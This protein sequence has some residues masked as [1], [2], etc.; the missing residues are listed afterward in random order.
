MN[1]RQ[2]QSIIDRIV[3]LTYRTSLSLERERE[4]EKWRDG[5][6]KKCLHKT[7]PHPNK[8]YYQCPFKENFYGG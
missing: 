3:Y 8:W 4:R 7:V 6:M 5:E 2:C 1:T